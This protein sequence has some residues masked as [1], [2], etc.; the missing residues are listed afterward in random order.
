MVKNNTTHLEDNREALAENAPYAL[1]LL[2]FVILLCSCPKEITGAR[3]LVQRLSSLPV[4]L[5]SI[6]ELIS[7]LAAMLM[8]TS[9]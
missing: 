6:G 7:V 5:I 1:F 4:R 3:I 9:C 2:Y 8:F